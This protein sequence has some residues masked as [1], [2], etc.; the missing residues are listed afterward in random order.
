LGTPIPLTDHPGGLSEHV[1][2]Q[3][4][5]QWNEPI[6]RITFHVATLMPQAEGD[7]AC[8]AK[9]SLI[10]NDFVSI[11][12]NE[13]GLPYRL[14]TLGG[15]VVHLV[16]EVLGLFLCIQNDENSGGIIPHLFFFFQLFSNQ[17][18]GFPHHKAKKKWLG[19]IFC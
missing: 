3:F 2:G 12:F 1:N 10:G 7:T 18:P 17:F 8:N 9:K 16:I 13:S 11:L 15:K 14:G 6:S 5:Y 4:T 19:Q